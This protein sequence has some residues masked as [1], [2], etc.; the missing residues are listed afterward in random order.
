MKRKELEHVL[1]AASQI[2]DQRD[3]LVI[4]SAAILGTYDDDVLPI[5][6]SRSEE[7]DLAPFDDPTGEKS[8]AVE[9]SLGQLS[10]FHAT[11]GYYA[12]GV[13]FATATAPEGWEDRLIAFE[14]PGAQPGR[15]MCLEP[16]DL[17][18]SK[19]AAGRIKDLEFV[20]AL[21]RAGLIE[22]A[23][24]RERVDLLPRARVPAAALGRARG[25]AQDWR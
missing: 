15:G 5:E 19:L 24:L 6:A 10:R 14:P 21:L 3:F 4:G 23:I 11:F 7:A 13:D 12:D 1:R 18:A 25:W 20:D 8:A 16:H 17:A 9:G 22:P 2:V